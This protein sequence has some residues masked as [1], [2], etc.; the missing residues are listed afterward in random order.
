MDE[1]VR[2]SF[3]TAKPGGRDYFSFSA[4][5][6]SVMTGIQGYLLHHLDGFGILSPVCGQ[7]V[8]DFLN[9]LR[10]GDWILRA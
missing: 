10:H 9:F 1:G 5:S 4:F 3:F 6:L 7:K 2:L 8:L